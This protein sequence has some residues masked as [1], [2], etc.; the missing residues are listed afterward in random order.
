MISKCFEY[1]QVGV[2][3]QDAEKIVRDAA[4]FVT[5]SAGRDRWH[6]VCIKRI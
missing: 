5:K 4:D 6:S 1:T 3:M 2:A